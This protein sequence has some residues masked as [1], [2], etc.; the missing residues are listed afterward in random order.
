[1]AFI[2]VFFTD[3]E[4]RLLHR[5]YKENIGPDTPLYEKLVQAVEEANEQVKWADY[6]CG[7]E[8]TSA[9]A[10]Y[11]TCPTHRRYEKIATD[12]SKWNE[13]DYTV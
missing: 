13:Y 10:G 8:N 12:Y 1:M 3:S 6:R 2:Q 7:H 4:I 5:L 11:K 9:R